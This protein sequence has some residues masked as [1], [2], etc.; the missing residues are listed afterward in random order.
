MTADALFARFREEVMTGAN[1]AIE[2]FAAQSAEYGRLV[3]R[4]AGVMP[5]T[6]RLLS[7]G[8]LRAGPAT[9]TFRRRRSAWRRRICVTGFRRR[10]RR[11]LCREGKRILS[12]RQ[13][14]RRHA[15]TDGV[16]RRHRAPVRSR[17]RHRICRPALPAQPSA[18]ER[19]KRPVPSS[20]G[21][22]GAC[23][24]RQRSRTKPGL[25]A[26]FLRNLGY[27]FSRACGRR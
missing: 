7:F 10:L 26:A 6:P 24:A 11:V 14:A 12:E 9:T 23:Q 13:P 4:R 15:A 17:H 16:A 2:K 18:P 20:G 19:R 21:R 22:E 8:E 27:E 1:E 5:A 3:G 25:E